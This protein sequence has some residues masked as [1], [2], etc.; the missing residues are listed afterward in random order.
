MKKFAVGLLA[1][2]LLASG[3]AVAQEHWTEGPVWECSAY[4]T[5]PGMFNTYIKWIRSHSEPIN[6]EAKKQ[7]LILDYKAFVKAP[8]DEND[9]D[10][11][12]CTLYSSYGKALD[13][14]KGDDEKFE[15][16][17]AAHWATADQDKQREQSA[18]R[19]EM[20]RFLGTT[21]V[22]EVNLRPIN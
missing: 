17:S 4:R 2:G 6:A 21:Y 19:L 14:N 18:P 12:F 10:V 15:K 8:S 9:Y 13:Y 3:A 16:I 20:R 22:R 11:L 1:A 5:N 7:G